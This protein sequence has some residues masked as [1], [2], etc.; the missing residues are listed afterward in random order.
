MESSS[1]TIREA[2]LTFLRNRLK[3]QSPRFHAQ[4]LRDYVASWGIDVAP[5]STDRILRLVRREGR[6]DYKVVS[7]SQSL[8]EALSA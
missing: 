3:H 5:A 2:V 4:E 8:Y 1:Y 7:R 6:A